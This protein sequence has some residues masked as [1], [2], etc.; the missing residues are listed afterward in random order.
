MNQAKQPTLEP[1]HPECIGVESH[2]SLEGVTRAWYI[3]YF[4]VVYGR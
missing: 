2:S 1:T 3:N 4:Y